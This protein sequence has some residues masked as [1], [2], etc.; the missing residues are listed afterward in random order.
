[1]SVR[2]TI[3]WLSGSGIAGRLQRANRSGWPLP[4]VGRRGI[5]D[6]P[7]H[8]IDKPYRD[9]VVDPLFASVRNDPAFDPML[10][11]LATHTR[12]A[13]DAFD[14]R[15]GNVAELRGED[16]LPP[17]GREEASGRLRTL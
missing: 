10:A 5:V 9:D 8:H 16:Q 11:T 17:R 15:E 3:G 13:P 6:L 1:V 14:T 4:L 12:D 2:T 7:G